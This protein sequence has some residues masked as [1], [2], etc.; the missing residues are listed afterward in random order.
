MTIASFG[1]IC[2]IRWHHRKCGSHCCGTGCGG[3][4]VGAG[5]VVIESS[6]GGGDE[7]ANMLSCFCPEFARQWLS[8]NLEVVGWLFKSTP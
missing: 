6:R 8:E 7:L 2:I 5:G 1:P 3:K 4:W